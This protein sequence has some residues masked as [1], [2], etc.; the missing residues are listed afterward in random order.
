MASNIV[1]LQCVCTFW[2]LKYHAHAAPA[3]FTQLTDFTIC[4]GELSAEYNALPG[5]TRVVISTIPQC[6]AWIYDADVRDFPP[7]E[8]RKPNIRYGL[9]T[10]GCS[11]VVSRKADVTCAS[12]ELYLRGWEVYASDRIRHKVASRTMFKERRMKR[13][14]TAQL[15]NKAILGGPVAGGKHMWSKTWTSFHGPGPELCEYIL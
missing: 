10:K 15:R 12:C 11:V 14:G 9:S 1:W 6:C 3:Y 13:I 7:P 2:S 4:H 8:I 5:M